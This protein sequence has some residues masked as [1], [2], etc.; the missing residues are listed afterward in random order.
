MKTASDE[1]TLAIERYLGIPADHV[2]F[3]DNVPSIPKQEFLYPEKRAGEA[4]LIF[5]SRI[6]PKKNLLQAIKCLKNISGAITFDIY[7]SLEDK[8]YW[9]LCQNEIKELPVNVTVNYCGLVTHDDVHR[10]FSNYD[11]FLFP[12][13][14]ENYGHVIIEALVTGCPV[15][16]SDKTPWN[17]LEAAGA[18]WVCQLEDIPAFGKAVQ[19]I[20]DSSDH[21]YRKHAKEYAMNCLD[22]KKIKSY[23][24]PERYSMTMPEE[25]YFCPNGPFEHI[26]EKRVS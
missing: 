25:E 9:E 24:R 20:V 13:F 15:I 11:A 17:D 16:I 2:F 10:T 7:G 4:K 1:E 8:A 3:L 23:F 6:H 5:L 22:V 12:T 19:M 21:T 14:S 26:N 18:G